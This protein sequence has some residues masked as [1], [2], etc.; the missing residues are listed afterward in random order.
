[1]TQRERF[2]HLYESGKRS[3]RQAIILFALITGISVTLMMIGERRL[4]EFIWF[5]LVFPSV[6]LVKIGARTNTL[7]RFNQSAEYKRLVRLEWW[8]AFGL[9][10]AYVVLILTLLLNPELI[11]VTVVATGTY[12]IG[13]IASSRLDQRLGKVD[14]E[15]V[16]HKVYARGKV[17]YFNS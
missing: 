1:M 13:I 15:H 4:A 8:T 3:T 2:N 10:G 5:L 17:G 7:L 12:G 6:G 14:P 9:I 16:T 11:S